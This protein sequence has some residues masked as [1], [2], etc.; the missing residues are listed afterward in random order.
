[1]VRLSDLQN[2][3]PCWYPYRDRYTPRHGRHDDCRQGVYHLLGALGKK[4][5]QVTKRFHGDSPRRQPVHTFNSGAHLFKSDS[6][7]KLGRIALRALQE[8]APD[9]QTSPTPSATSTASQI[10]STPAS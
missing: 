4:N 1:M 3:N 8:Y 5:I 9:P 7:Q 2:G 6:V 10:A